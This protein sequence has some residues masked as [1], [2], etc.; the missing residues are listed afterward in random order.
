MSHQFVQMLQNTQRNKVISPFIK[1]R[2]IILGLIIII[3]SLAMILYN[4]N[5]LVFLSMIL[6]D[7]GVSQEN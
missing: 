2:K 6:R 7:H 3:N 1:T 4:I 5:I